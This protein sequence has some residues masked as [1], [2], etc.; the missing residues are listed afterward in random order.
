MR[1]GLQPARWIL[2]L[3]LLYIPLHSPLTCSNTNTR[4]TLFFSSRAHQT[5]RLISN[6]PPSA[7][8]TSLTF[9]TIVP[10]L[11]PHR[12]YNDEH[13]ILAHFSPRPLASSISFLVSPCELSP[14]P[15]CLGYNNEQ[16]GRGRISRRSASLSLPNLIHP[17]RWSS[18]HSFRTTSISPKAS[19]SAV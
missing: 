3:L 1:R 13:D 16:Y 12:H 11:H 6:T 14:T 19:L 18:K 8:I 15:R 4:I 9:P 7:H 2:H 10:A 17:P 5:P